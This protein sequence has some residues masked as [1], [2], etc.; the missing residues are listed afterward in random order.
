MTV[1]LIA[2]EQF[3]STGAADFQ[4]FKFNGTGVALS[5]ITV[6][7]HSPALAAATGTF[8]GDGTGGF[9]FGI[10]CPTC[11][12]GPVGFGGSIS[13]T[14]ANATIADVTAPNNLGNIFVAD[15]LGL[16]GNTGPV[17]VTGTP[18][19]PEPGTLTLLGTGLVALGLAAR[20]R[21][22]AGR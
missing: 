21:F 15:I 10:N 14:V 19:V 12:N 4:L 17:D 22:T 1:T 7:A 5:D 9:T 13:F 11:G 18:S 8:N 2:G 3:A 6:G 20:R 16:T